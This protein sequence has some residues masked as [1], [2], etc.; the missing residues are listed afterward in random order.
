MY[1]NTRVIEALFGRVGWKQPT[2]AGMPGL[3][4]PNTLSKSGKYFNSP[5]NHAAVTIQN[6]WQSQEDPDISDPDF[7]LFLEDMQKSAIQRVMD[8]VFAHNI[9]VIETVQAFDRETDIVDTVIPNQN[10]FVG[11]RITIGPNTD[12]AV[13]L[14]SLAFYFDQSV[15]FEMKCFIDNSSQAIWTK[16]VN[17]IGGELTIVPVD[18]LIL[19]YMSNKSVSRDFYIGYFQSDIGDAQAYDEPV[20]VYRRGCM[21]YFDAF[22]SPVSGTKFV[23]P[24]TYSSKT[25]GFNPQ[26]TTYR[27]LTNR[28]VANAPLFDTAVSLQIACDTIELILNSTRSNATERISKEQMGDLYKDLNLGVPSE[29]QVFSPGLKYRL[30]NEIKK[31]HKSFFGQARIESHSLPYEVYQDRERGRGYTYP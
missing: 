15:S 22:E 11:Y 20:L 3:T 19:S 9:E 13:A 18:D 30:E 23:V 16:T 8:S 4:E 24:P 27:D 17:V 12:F 7:N 5:S 6:I 14:S 31:L 1:N 29:G 26:F 21:F 2:L 25:Y 10:Y 28:I